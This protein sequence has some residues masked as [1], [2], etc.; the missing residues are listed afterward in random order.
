MLI[1]RVGCKVHETLEGGPV[2]GSRFKKEA[3]PIAHSSRLFLYTSG[4]ATE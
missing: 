3:L 4:V 1:H 2:G